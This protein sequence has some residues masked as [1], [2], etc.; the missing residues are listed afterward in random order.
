MSLKHYLSFLGTALLAFFV[1]TAEAKAATYE[2]KQGDTISTIAQA[3]GTTVAK[4]KTT[5]NLR[6]NTIAAGQTLT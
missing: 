1:F 2:V 4:L 6:S 3:H 5:N